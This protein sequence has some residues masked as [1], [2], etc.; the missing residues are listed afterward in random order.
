MSKRWTIVDLGLGNLHSVQRAVERVGAVPSLTRDPDAVAR[1]D[2]L[3]VP[4]QGGFARGAESLE[5]GMGEALR[6][7]VGS[8]RPYFGI[9]LGMQ[10]LFERSEEAPDAKGLGV[11]GGSV[12]RL[13]PSGARKVPHMGWN[14]L[15]TEHPLLDAGSWFYFVHSFHCV[16]EDSSLIAA[17]VDYGG[18]VCAA[19]GWGESFAVQFHPEKSQRRGEALLSKF[20]EE[21]EAA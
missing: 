8:G 18:P 6:E 4:G 5:G 12:D 3:L 10:L 13:R 11:F 1:A 14:A 17:T 9:C 2:R 7:H 21:R 20:L 16:P 19:I 15:E